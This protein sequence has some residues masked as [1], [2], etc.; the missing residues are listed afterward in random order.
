[1]NGLDETRVT[2]AVEV[3]A[4]ATHPHLWNGK[5]RDVLLRFTGK[6][7]FTEAEVDERIESKRQEARDKARSIL[8]AALPVLAGGIAEVIGTATWE[9]GSQRGPLAGDSEETW[10]RGANDGIDFAQA[11]VRASGKAAV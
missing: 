9:E 11:V 7:S 4:Q 1:M 5:F 8:T 6:L 3:A 10:M 2:A